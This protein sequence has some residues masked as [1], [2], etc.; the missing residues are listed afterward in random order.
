MNLRPLLI[1]EACNPEWVSIPLEG[2][3]LSRAIS[4]LTNAHLV[5][6]IR[7]RDAL[8]RAGLVEGKDF[9]AIDSEA[10]ARRTH[11]LA[12]ALGG[13]QGKGWTLNT[14]LSSLSYRYFEKLLWQQFG[15]R[16]ANHEFDLVHRI[17]PS[18][19]TI[20]SRLATLCKNAGVPMVLGPLNG[21]LLW[22]PGFDSAR[23][24]EREWLSYIRG[25]YRMLPGSRAT[26]RDASAIIAGSRHTASQQPPDIAHKVFYIPENGI[27]PARFSVLRTRIAQRPLR[28]VFLGRLVPYKGP[29]MLLEAAAPLLAA[30]DLTI[31]F[32]GDGPMK[33]DLVQLATDLG[34]AEKVRF[35][36][37]I[38][39][40]DLPARLAETDLLTFPSIREFGGAVVLE[41]MAVGVVPV[42]VNYGGPAELATSDTG[43]L[44]PLA[45][46]PEIVA[47]LRKI[48]TELVANPSLINDRSAAARQRAMEHFAWPVKAREVLKIY[49]RVCRPS[50]SQTNLTPPTE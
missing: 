46:R 42:I 37:W 38:D 3:S 20:P 16:I 7:N 32:I 29:D 30:G 33:L 31:D 45:K 47:S 28:A 5:T 15:P 34:V 19:P 8:L 12:W 40:A 21:G 41:A 4:E 39:H 26:L 18:S 43:F 1:A 17:T 24:R 14:A 25:A 2:W 13:Q 49:E 44:I 6:Q 9:T 23:R 10:V 48:L 50:D 35:L 22:P 36:G 27:D 11:K